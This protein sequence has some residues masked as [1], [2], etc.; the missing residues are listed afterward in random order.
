MS[1]TKN[2]IYKMVLSGMFLAT[3]LLLPFLT[4]QIPEFGSMLCPMHLPVLLCGF[5]C[6]PVYGLCVGAIAPLIRFALFGMPPLLPSGVG[7][8]FELAA[9]GLCAGLL[10][11]LLPQKKMYIYVTLITSM[12][13]GRIVWGIARA[14]MYGAGGYKFGMAA[15]VAGAFVDALPGIV[16]QI[17]LIPLIVM[18]VEKAFPE[19]AD[20]QRS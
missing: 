16:L 18:A 8:C 10:Y 2:K 15:F 9:Y 6:G 20:S 4:A 17:V 1:S 12:I 7:M 19:F 3:A 14:V 11:K 5:F 13:F